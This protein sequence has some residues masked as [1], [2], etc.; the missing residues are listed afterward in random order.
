MTTVK[1]I[2]RLAG[3]YGLVLILPFYG[4]E[5]RIGQ[6]TPPPITHPEYFYGFVGVTAAT[7][8]LYLLIS[9]DPLRYRPA[10]PVAALMKLSFAVAVFWLAYAGRAA[11]APVTFAGVDGVIGVLFAAAFLLTSPARSA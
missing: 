9:T 4:L 6:D 2:F 3:L 7:Q 8:L 1:W 11:G 5:Q 10:M